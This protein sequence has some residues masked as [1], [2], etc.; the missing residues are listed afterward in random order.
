MSLRV[1]VHGE[2]DFALPLLRDLLRSWDEAASTTSELV[3]VEGTTLLPEIDRGLD[4]ADG[5]IVAPSDWTEMQAIAQRFAGTSRIVAVG[6]DDADVV[7]AAAVGGI[8]VVRGRGLEGFRWAGS[9]LRQRL[10]YPFQEH[11]YGDHP[12]QVGD[13]RLPL[14]GE[15]TFP[16]AVCLHGGFWRERWL[17]DTIEPTAIELARRGFATFNVE[18]RRAGADFGGWR[19]TTGDV[20]A[21]IDYVAALDA[22]FDRSRIALVGHSAGAQLAAWAVARRG[23]GPARHDVRPAAVVL[24]AGMVDLEEAARRGLGDTG[25]PTAAFLGGTSDGR[26]DDYEAASPRSN[27]PLG[28]PQ[29]VVQGLQDSPDFVDMNRRYVERATEAGDA[30]TYL[31]PKD[32]DHFTVI[33]PA[34]DEWQAMASALDDALGRHPA[35]DSP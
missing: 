13:L 35:S 9:W 10:D 1:V 15:P 28:V 17:R 5:V 21:A 3:A 32:G 4:D 27:L 23:L 20:A 11:S 18:Y 33:T 25:N 26:R 8:P 30:V 7:S 29:I 31:E 6:L 22:R 12:D 24:L 2:P 34:R 14:E 16:V 19:Q